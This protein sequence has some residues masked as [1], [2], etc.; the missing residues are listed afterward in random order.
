[1]PVPCWGLAAGHCL[2]INRAGNTAFMNTDK[3]GVDLSGFICVRCRH[4]PLG[5]AVNTSM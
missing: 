3:M 5:H 4:K 1:M 2:D